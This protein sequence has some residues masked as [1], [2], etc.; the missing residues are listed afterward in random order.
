MEITKINALPAPPKRLKVCGYGRVS[1]GKDAMLHSLA[2][3]VDYFSKL[4]TNNPEWEYAGVYADEA[5]TGTKE[6]CEGFQSMLTACLEGKVDLIVTKS[7]SRF[8]RNTLTVLES[9][10]LLRDLNID[11]FFEEQNIHSLSADGELMLT[12]LASFAQEESLSASENQKWRI[13]KHF[14][15]GIQGNGSAPLGYR[16]EGD[17]LIIVPEEA[18]IVRFVFTE[19][20]SGTGRTA[21][22][23]MLRSRYGLPTTHMGVYDMLRNEKYCGDLLLQKYFIT[24]HISKHQKKNKG[25]KPQ[26]AV[27]GNHEPI[28][29]R[30][31]FA[32]TQA[33]IARRINS[34]HQRDPVYGKF[35]YT[36]LI[37][38][39]TSGRAYVCKHTAFGSKY[40][41]MAWVCT[42]S[43]NYGAAYCPSRRIPNDI[44]DGVV[45][46]LGGIDKIAGITVFPDLLKIE[47]TDGTHIEKPWANPSRSKS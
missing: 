3:Q 12:L 33:E 13:R 47:L 44:V 22:A 35:T 40:D 16:F 23:K 25:Q 19:Y 11:I 21:I 10:R 46:E 5:K 37:K 29:S 39:G 17:N 18:E 15:N 32:A 1:S 42:T 20:L 38:C 41:K 36:G 7:I 43:L 28:I 14:E 4:I 26:Y 2:A 31:V 27:K 24:D 9:V 6:T 45:A 34:H 30:K 8:A